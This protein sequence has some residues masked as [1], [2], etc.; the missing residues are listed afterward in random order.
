MKEILIVGGIGLGAF[1][2]WRA[3]RRNAN[4][5]PT[6][7]DAPTRKAW[8]PATTALSTPSVSANGGGTRQS[9]AL[10]SIIAQTYGTVED[11]NLARLKLH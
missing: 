10:Q 1:V 3:W 7:Q 9:R 2:L 5:A 11:P 4:P 6:M 8:D